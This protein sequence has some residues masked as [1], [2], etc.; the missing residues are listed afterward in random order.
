MYCAVH[1]IVDEA[2]LYQTKKTKEIKRCQKQLQDIKSDK[3]R[4][5][6]TEKLE[7]A[8]RAIPVR[9][10]AEKTHKETYT[11]SNERGAACGKYGW[12]LVC[13]NT[14]NSFCP[15]TK[16]PVCSSECRGRHQKMMEMLSMYLNYRNEKVKYVEDVIMLFKS[17]CKLSHKDMA[18]GG[19]PISE[20]RFKAPMAAL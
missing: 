2:C 1:S 10:A 3:T 9:A 20:A 17:A 4:D 15:T 19:D 16:V 8:L 13:R 11:M 6:I 12:C 7:R 18:N 14:A 5:E